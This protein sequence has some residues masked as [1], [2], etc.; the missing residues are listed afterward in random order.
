M[1]ELGCSIYLS[2]ATGRERA[3]APNSTLTN[4][5]VDL[6]LSALIDDIFGVWRLEVDTKGALPQM[7]AQTDKTVAET[8]NAEAKQQDA[9]WPGGNG[10]AFDW[11]TK[12]CAC[13]GHAR[14][15]FFTQGGRRRGR[16]ALAVLAKTL[17]V[18]DIR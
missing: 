10:A 12:V 11:T 17:G 16:L 5:Y 13:G 3:A 15:A 2:Q 14:G 9:R 7:K 6:C 8:M 1:C 18:G 4:K